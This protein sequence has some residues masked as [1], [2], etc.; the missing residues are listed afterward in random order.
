VGE[1]DL[2]AS[3]THIQ[4]PPVTGTPRAKLISKVM[5]FPFTAMF[6]A[7]STIAGSE[8]S[9]M[10]TSTAPTTPDGSMSF[11]PVLQASHLLDAFD[12]AMPGAGIASRLES[13]FPTSL[14]LNSN[15]PITV[16]NICCVGAGY[17]GKL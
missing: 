8:Y 13:I 5:A 4:N 14:D 7:P 17:V 1:K 11:S 16:K 2:L 6:E 15:A 12:G 10:E 3:A 9:V